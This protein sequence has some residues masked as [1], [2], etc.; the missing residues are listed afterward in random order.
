MN[1]VKNNNIKNSKGEINRERKNTNKKLSLSQNLTLKKFENNNL[2]QN[3]ENKKYNNKSSSKEIKMN[4]L[5][6]NIFFLPKKEDT[7]LNIK[8][9]PL[10]DGNKI[11]D[12]KKKKMINYSEI[13]EEFCWKNN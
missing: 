4:S 12:S 3:K 9:I 10:T 11:S 13:N 8:K 1:L 5:E 2:I 6:S 7:N